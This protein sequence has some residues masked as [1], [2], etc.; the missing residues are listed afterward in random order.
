MAESTKPFQVGDWRVEPRLNRLLRGDE[1]VTLQPGAMD[2]LVYLTRQR[3]V[4]TTEELLDALWPGRFVV[5][6]VVH[7]R[8]AQIRRAFGDDARSPRYV[9]TIPGRGYRLIAPVTDAEASPVTAEERRWKVAILRFADLSPGAELGWL[10]AGL[11]EHLEQQVAV[12]PRFEVIPGVIAADAADVG[13]LTDLMITGFLERQRQNV[14]LNASVVDLRKRATLWSQAFTGRAEDPFEL[15][16]QLVSTTARY[17]GESLG[18]IPVPEKPEAYADFLRFLNYRIYGDADEHLFWLSR[19]LEAD[20]GWAWG[21]VD[22]AQAYAR[23]AAVLRQPEL[24]EQAWQMLASRPLSGR[25]DAYACLTRTFLWTCWRGDLTA[26]ESEARRWLPRWGA[27]YAMLLQASGLLRESAHYARHAIAAH[28]HE[29]YLSELLSVSLAGLGDWRG[30]Q[31]VSDRVAALYPADCVNAQIVRSWSHRRTAHGD[32]SRA[33]CAYL[34]RALVDAPPGSVQRRLV[35][36]T[37]YY[38]LAFEVAMAEG[39]LT[40]AGTIRDW[41][42]EQGYLAMAVVLSLRLNGRCAAELAASAPDPVLDRFWWWV[43]RLHLTPEIADHPQYK[44]LEERM[45]FN[46]TWRAELA[47]RAS[48]LD[49]ASHIVVNPDDYAL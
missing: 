46:D 6:A 19:T 29:V 30:A 13:P 25:A 21:V 9:E 42:Q 38:P 34:K 15:L 40:A 31:A 33:L 1:T 23:N 27:P 28:P 8:I 22:L 26:A 39:D 3:N 5:Q 24:Y 4:V 7:Q 16:Q 48:T 32:A 43:N 47:R 41:F 11:R 35:E 2:L 44:A 12:W 37:G 49:P 10:A 14:V 45:G 18:G 20:P 36:Y 17:F